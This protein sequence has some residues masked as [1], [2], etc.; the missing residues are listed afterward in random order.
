[1]AGSFAL[2]IG[3][4]LLLRLGTAALVLQ[5][6]LLSALAALIFGRFCLGSFL[7]HL[8]RGRSDIATGTLP[9]KP[10]SF[11][12]PQSRSIVGEGKRRDLSASPGAVKNRSMTTRKGDKA[13]RFMMVMIPRV[14][15]PDTPPGE[16][17]GDGF[18]PAAEDVA[19]MMRFNEELAKAGALIA[20]D[21]LHPGSK[22]AR[23]SFAGGKP[24]VAGGPFTGA[25]EVIGGY[26]MIE[27]KSKEE[28]VGWAKRCPAADG[29]VIE[30]RQ[31]FE[32]SDFPQDVR[33][34]AENPMVREHLE[35]RKAS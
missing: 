28:A 31:V 33:T 5:V 19:K 4:L 6:L 8:L 25:K 14:Y 30:V 16:K 29:D 11:T 13:M 27:A 34:A 7:Y 24:K 1:M 2:A 23:V 20:L 9:W 26:W 12:G 15:Q 32:A 3:I 10:W 22:G 18:A 17:A 35:K 21:G